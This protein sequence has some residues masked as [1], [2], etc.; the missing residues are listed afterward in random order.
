MPK[1]L[2]SYRRHN[3]TL[4]NHI[5]IYRGGV[6]DRQILYVGMK[7][8]VSTLQSRNCMAVCPR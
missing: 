8:K 2:H 6:G 5:L 7:C 1:A 3:N 4:L